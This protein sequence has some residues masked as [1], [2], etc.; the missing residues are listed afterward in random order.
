MSALG[1]LLSGLL[2]AA[3]TLSSET[4]IRSLL[5]E[6]A[7]AWNR[8]D[9]E[10]YLGGYEKSDELT[11]FAGGTITRGWQATLDRYRARYQS[12]GRR[13]GTLTFTDVTVEVLGPDV[14]IARGRWKLTL[15]GGR[16]P[17]GL[18]TLVLRKR[19][20][21]WRITHDHSSAE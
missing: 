7:A 14:A 1:H 20:E 10:G 19:T 6:Q 4:A 18:F 15:E 3:P 9:L 16:E 21:G 5:D 13:M 12:G 8:G 2:A 17:K 11:F